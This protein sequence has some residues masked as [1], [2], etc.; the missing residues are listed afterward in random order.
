ML[1]RFLNDNAIDLKAIERIRHRM[2][3]VG[4]F[5]QSRTGRSDPDIYL[6]TNRP[7][8]ELP[9]GYLNNFTLGDKGT[10]AQELDYQAFVKCLRPALAEF[11]DYE[12][13]T[14]ETQ[15]PK[16]RQVVPRDNDKAAEGAA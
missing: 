8:S 2:W 5:N 14:P 10:R 11:V 4:R 15:I 16:I 3:V 9:A 6:F 1:E 12:G 13:N 7:A